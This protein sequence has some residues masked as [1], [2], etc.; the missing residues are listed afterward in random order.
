MITV[1]KW[2]WPL[3]LAL[4]V[5]VGGILV[6][7]RVV[8][9][10][11][12]TQ[13]TLIYSGNTREV[14]AELSR[15]GPKAADASIVRVQGQPLQIQMEAEAASSQLVVDKLERASQNFIQS[16]VQ[17]RKQKADQLRDTYQ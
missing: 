12:V 15:F 3:I 7:A 1:G 8:Q 14:Q 9:P 11:Y 17:Y 2:R 10:R 4:P 5:V 16:S 13:T 6:G